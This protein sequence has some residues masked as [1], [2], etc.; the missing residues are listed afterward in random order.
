MIIQSMKS[1]SLILVL[2][3]VYGIEGKNLD[4]SNGEFKSPRFKT[5][6]SEDLLNYTD[7]KAM[8]TCKPPFILVGGTC[9]MVDFKK[10]MSWRDARARC[11]E[12]NAD[13][14]IFR[15]ANMFAAAI[16][17]IKKENFGSV[18]SNIWIGGSDID[19]EGIWLWIDGTPMPRGTPFWGSL[20]EKQEPFAGRPNEDC[21]F[22]HYKTFYYIHDAWC[23]SEPMS[24]GVPLCQYF[25]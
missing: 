2:V 19:T 15:D 21:A 4:Q 18:K 14:A 6:N 20:G 12:F 5:S 23:V 10:E 3:F 7:G 1:I 13:L 8:P 22:L 11:S 9:M 16:E 24:L 17:F 25:L